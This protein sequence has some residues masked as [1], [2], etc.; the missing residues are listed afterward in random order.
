MTPSIL[1]KT[2]RKAVADFKRTIGEKLRD[3]GQM[4]DYLMR[5][6]GNVKDHRLWMGVSTLL[7]LISSTKLK[8]MRPQTDLDEALAFSNIDSP[9]DDIQHNALS[10]ANTV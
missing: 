6:S 5:T 7:I 3:S 10:G 2:D 8:L 9:L 4:H 1:A